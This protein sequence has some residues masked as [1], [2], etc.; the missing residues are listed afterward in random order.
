[1]SPDPEPTSPDPEP[2]WPDPQPEPDMP[3]SHDPVGDGEPD[4]DLD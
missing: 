1:M 3:P 4:P 2:E